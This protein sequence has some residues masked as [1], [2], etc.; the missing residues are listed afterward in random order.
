MFVSKLRPLLGCALLLAVGGLVCTSCRE[1][2]LVPIAKDGAS[3]SSPAKSGAA[4]PSVRVTVVQVTPQRLAEKIVATG[5][6][7]AEEGVELQAEITGKIVA[8]GFK[9]GAQ[10][11]RGDLLV[12]L[13]DADLKA[14]LTRAVFRRDLAEI[15]E[16]RLA[17]LLE[18]QSVRQEDYDIA[19]SDLNVQRA[20]VALVEA[21]VNKTEIRAPFDGVVGLR[22]VSEGAFVNA[23]SRIATLQSLGRVKVD[24][25]VPEKYGPRIKNGTTISFT[26]AGL[27]RKFRG[28][29]YASDPRI[30]PATRTLLLR[31]I[32]P[33]NDGQ[34]LPGTFASVELTLSEINDAILVPSVAV[35][36][37][38]SEKYVFVI[39]EGKAVRKTVQVGTRTETS[40]QVIDGLQLG[41]VVIISGIQQLRD[42][43]AVKAF[44]TPAKEIAQAG[45]KD[46]TSGGGGDRRTK[47]GIDGSR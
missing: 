10:V 31:A 19:V 26:V 5:S 15:K 6:L 22:F 12:K 35:V 17:K 25:S 29:V 20:E 46:G 4:T 37:G 45:A 9:E 44:E 32:C 41:D 23:A 30:D 24:F 33:N 13:N 21:T 18:S 3:K 36:P 43:L 14:E 38:V 47:E 1:R 28:E 42:G 7:R 8:M 34:L 11:Q 27:D 39:K 2:A 40:V 16:R